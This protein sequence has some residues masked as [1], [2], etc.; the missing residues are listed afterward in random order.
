MDYLTFGFEIKAVKDKHDFFEFEGLAST[1]GNIDHDGDAFAKGAFLESIA[2]R[3]PSMMWQHQWSE[4]IGVFDVIKE[5]KEGLFVKGRMP[6]EDSLVRDRVIPQI[7][8]GSVRT[9]SV[10][11]RINSRDDVEIT[12]EGIRI[13]KKVDLFEISLVTIPAN[14]MAVVTAFKGI[15][16]DAGVPD[17]KIDMSALQDVAHLMTEPVDQFDDIKNMK[18]LNNALA[19]VGLG[20]SARNSL[21]A[22]VKNSL[23]DAGDD[24]VERDAIASLTAKAETLALGIV[25]NN[26]KRMLKNG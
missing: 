4:P 8:I 5:T 24:E 9:M 15:M 20:R 7:K 1:F 14:D 23:R 19:S 17:D 12:S 3:T 26:T 2:K 21:I 13:I 25:I 6:K 16:H 22:A 18:E 11:F 10:G